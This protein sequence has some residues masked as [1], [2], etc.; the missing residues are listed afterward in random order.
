VS[1]FLRR[2]RAQ[3]P[4]TQEGL[5]DELRDWK[6]ITIDNTEQRISLVMRLRICRPALPEKPRFADAIEISWPYQSADSFP[7]PDDNQKQLAFERLLDDL[8]GSN[9]FSE[10]VQVTT[11]MGKKQWLYY[12]CSRDRFMKEFN[13]RLEGHERYPLTIEFYEDPEWQI[14]AQAVESLAKS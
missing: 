6:V 5:S 14:W 3:Q 8:S 10:L 7:R 13:A 9:G 1:W 4:A 12:C 11:G 2:R